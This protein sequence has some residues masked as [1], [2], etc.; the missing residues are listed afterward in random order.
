[1]ELGRIAEI[2]NA[3]MNN[4]QKV[5]K[6]NETDEKQK[7]D[8][9]EQHKKVLPKDTEPNEVILDNVSFGFNKETK[10]FF[11]KVKKGNIEY[12]YPTDD[13]MKLKASLSEALESKQVK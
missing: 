5:Q 10:D 9:N 4:I 7:V 13:M 6:V 12:K 2:D 3:K 11:V 1:M 8:P